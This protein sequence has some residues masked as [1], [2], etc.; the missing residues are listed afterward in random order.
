MLQQEGLIVAEH[1]KR[2]R[3]MSFDPE[4]IDTNF[5][6]VILLASLAAAVSV[7]RLTDEDIAPIRNWL[8][9]M[10]LAA[11]RG[12]LDGWKQADEKF[13]AGAFMYAGAPLDR[14]LKRAY[15]Q[16]QF[17]LRFVISRDNVP[18]ASV[19]GQHKM[20]LDACAA[21]NGDLAARLVARHIA[22][23]G[24]ILLADAMPER[25]PRMIRAAMRLIVQK[26]EMVIPK[27]AAIG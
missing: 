16:N 23:A 27:R 15:D 19:H 8:K 25:E 17:Y 4:V 7:P 26:P 24:I 12:D 13:H 3:L 10:R 20:I 11:Q 2:P 6:E 14:L 1:N 18:W 9:Q 21:R 5:A 22:N